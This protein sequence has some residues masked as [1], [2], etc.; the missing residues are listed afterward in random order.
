M[1]G[2]TKPKGDLDA[3]RTLTKRRKE[4]GMSQVELS[5][6]MDLDKAVW[7]NVERGFRNLSASEMIK[8]CEILG[9]EV[10]LRYKA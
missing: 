2:D 5:N 3:V 4:I 1:S 8:A 7:G 6:A 10:I 9:L